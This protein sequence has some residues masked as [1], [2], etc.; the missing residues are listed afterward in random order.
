M[1]Q[2][3]YGELQEGNLQVTKD[4]NSILRLPTDTISTL[5]ERFQS[6]QDVAKELLTCAYL[7]GEASGSATEQRANR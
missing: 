6:P 3:V 4:L 5:K 7:K 2:L 1:C